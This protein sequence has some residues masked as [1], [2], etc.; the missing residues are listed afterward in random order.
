[1]PMPEHCSNCDKPLREKH[2]L[3]RCLFPMPV[4][5]SKG[6]HTGWLHENNMVTPLKDG[7]TPL[8]FAL[9]DEEKVDG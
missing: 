6:H 1:M 5:N 9:K 7:E 4:Y 2:A 3:C 8:P